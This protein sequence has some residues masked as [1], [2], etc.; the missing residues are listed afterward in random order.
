[1]KLSLGCSI[2]LLLAML[3]GWINNLVYIFSAIDLGI[4]PH[5]ILAVVGA[6]FAPLGA[7]H[8]LY[9]FF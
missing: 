3:V 7:L 6:I 2:L 5:W 8:G 9:L 1:M 4:T